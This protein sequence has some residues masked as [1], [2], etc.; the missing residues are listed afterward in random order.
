[1]R[2][3]FT[4]TASRVYVDTRPLAVATATSGRPD[5][6]GCKNLSQREI[7]LSNSLLRTV[8]PFCIKDSRGIN[9][10]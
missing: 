9:P 1:V 7:L 6:S 2:S 5:M 3:V 4:F 10:L 8:L